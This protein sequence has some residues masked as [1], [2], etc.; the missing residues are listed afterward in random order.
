MVQCNVRK[1]SA[2]ANLK[3]PQEKQDESA[4][5]TG[6]YSGLYSGLKRGRLQTK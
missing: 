6:L 3:Q 4:S 1:C 2:R 5:Q